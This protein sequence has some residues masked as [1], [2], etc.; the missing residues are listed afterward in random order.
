[1]YRACVFIFALFASVLV[2]TASPVPE[3]YANSTIISPYD[4]RVTHTGRGTWYYV[5]LGNCGYTDVDS[6]P[7]VA[8][9]KQRYDTNNGANCDQWVQIVNTAN[10]KMAYG[11]T[12]DSCESC[13]IY[14]LDM[15][16]SLFEKLAPLSVGELTI[17]W[18]F[19][20]MDWSP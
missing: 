3:T 5:G 6:S 17:S 13:G 10:G 16:P 19:M 8:I 7:I 18:H 20:A 2:A 12:R 9:S 4:K 11:K 14:D 1:M 15:S